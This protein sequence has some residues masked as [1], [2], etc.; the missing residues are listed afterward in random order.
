MLFRRA[1]K[2]SVG[3][4]LAL[5]AITL[6][7]AKEF[8]PPRPQ[9]ANTYASK[10][11]HPNDKVTAAIELYNSP[12]KNEIFVTPYSE[13]QLVPVFLI[14]SN[15]GDQ[16]ITLNNMRVELVTTRRAK[17]ESLTTDDIFRRVSRVGASSTSPG[18]V[19]PLPMPGK[20]K[21]KKAQ[22]EYAEINNASFAAQA[23]EPHTTKSGFLFFDVAGV[24]P[25]IVEGAHIYLTGIRDANGNELLYFDIPVIS[26][27]AAN[28]GQ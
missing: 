12:P 10:D 11:A 16:P 24:A 28:P 21:N 26:Q 25:P 17:L 7:A 18:R 15:D 9:N 5:A 8:V 2:V 6:Q 27:N 3:L 23:I 13:Y 14:I 22:Q 4:A 19:G 1:L 20:N